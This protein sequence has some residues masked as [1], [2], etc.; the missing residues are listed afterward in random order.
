MNCGRVTRA[1]FGH[2][3][4]QLVVEIHLRLVGY[5]GSLFA[6]AHPPRMCAGARIL[7]L[8]SQVVSLL[9]LGREQIAKAAA[10]QRS[11]R[12]WPWRESGNWNW[13]LFTLLLLL[14]L[15]PLAFI[16]KNP[17]RQIQFETWL[18]T[19]IHTCLKSSS[20]VAQC[21]KMCWTELGLDFKALRTKIPC[22]LWCKN[23]IYE[24]R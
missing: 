19:R 9:Y 22:A 15:L 7:Y 20:G 1:S 11:K 12:K 8:V 5:L 23:Y 18:Q 3:K 13:N 21:G 14:S 24:I 17:K 2:G 16:H 6:Q 4:R 10:Q